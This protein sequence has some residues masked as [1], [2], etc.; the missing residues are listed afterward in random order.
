MARQEIGHNIKG[1][2]N[3]SFKLWWFIKQSWIT[4]WMRS[5]PT[6][7]VKRLSSEGPWEGI[8]M[9]LYMYSYCIVFPKINILNWTE[10]HGYIIRWFLISLCATTGPYEK[11]YLKNH[12]K[13]P[14]D[15]EQKVLEISKRYSYCNGKQVKQSKIIQ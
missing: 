7:W 14:L 5:W 3:V 8:T 4:K 13:N 6:Y 10:P 9:W 12:Y 1:W 15:W 2:H 11:S